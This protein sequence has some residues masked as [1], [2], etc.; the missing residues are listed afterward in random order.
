[1]EKNIN[2]LNAKE[3]QEAAGGASQG[4]IVYVV[5]KGDTLTKIAGRYGVT[6]A[7]LV[8]WNNIANPNLI[9]VGQKLRIFI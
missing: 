3:L 9:L 1:M 8:Q 4:Y 5:Q 7:Q 6:V 2:E